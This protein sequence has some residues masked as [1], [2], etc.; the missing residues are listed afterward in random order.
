M[1]RKKRDQD[2]RKRERVKGHLNWNEN[3][4]KRIFQF[5]LILYAVSIPITDNFK[6]HSNF[7][8]CFGAPIVHISFTT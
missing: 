1:R 8:S 6:S 4:E 3:H 2:Y 5:H 7:I